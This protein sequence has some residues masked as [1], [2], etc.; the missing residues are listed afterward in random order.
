MTKIRFVYM[1][2]Y[3]WR[4]TYKRLLQKRNIIVGMCFFCELF[5]KT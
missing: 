5:V 1:I 4:I 2:G 3:D